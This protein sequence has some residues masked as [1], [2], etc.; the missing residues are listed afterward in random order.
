MLVA[1]ADD[2]FDEKE[3]ELLISLAMG[4]LEEFNGTNLVQEQIGDYEV[5]Y[6]KSI[7]I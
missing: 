6:L 7:V 4:L 1:A 5:K 3:Q 2:C